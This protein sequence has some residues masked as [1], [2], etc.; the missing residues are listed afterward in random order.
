MASP[1]SSRLDAGPGTRDG[2][3]NNDGHDSSDEYLIPTPSSG[4]SDEEVPLLGNERKGSAS[5]INSSYGITAIGQNP[6]RRPFW[7]KGDLEFDE[8]AIA[9]QES[10]FDE[11]TLAERYRPSPD[12]ENIH[13]FD[14]SA[15]WTW[16]EERAVVRKIDRR[17]MSFACIAFMAL[18]LDRANL[19]QALS[20]NFLDDLGLSTNDFNLGHS[21][22]RLAFLCIE[23]PSQ[24]LSKRIGPDRFLP[25]QMCLWS[26]V[27]ISQFWLQGKKSF[28]VTRALL[29]LFEG[30]F[31]PEIILYL[32]YFYKSQELSIRVAVFY[33]TMSL[34][35][36]FAGFI[37][38][39]LLQMRGFCGLEGWRWLFLIEGVV[40]FVVGMLAA[41]LIPPSITETASWFRG[42]NGWFNKREETIMVNRVLR[43]DPSKGDMHNRQAITWKL[44]R[45][46]LL[47]YDLWPLYILGILWSLPVVPEQQYFT[48]I[49]RDQGFSTS[50]TNLLTIPTMF[51]SMITVTAITH[52]SELYN[53]RS[54]VSIISQLWAL[55]FLVW[56]YA[57]D[58]SEANPWLVW[59]ILTLLIA[60]PSPHAILVSWNSRNSNSVRL[61]TISAAI[62]N[63]CVQTAGMIGSN[64]YRSDDRPQ[65]RRGNQVLIGIACFNITIYLVVKVYYMWRNKF[66]SEKWGTMSEE[67]KRQYLDASQDAGNKRLEFVFAH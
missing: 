15:R 64:I 19:S 27:S 4:S 31:I 65:Y 12:W 50:V 9:T 22:F 35:N 7:N 61:R 28:I 38:V 60:Y 54:L 44:F 33:A 53:E 10:V 23:L 67:E 66:K 30:G 62:Y 43:D 5:T 34:A 58:T 20:D 13:R 46:S 36:I 8:D 39:P 45:Q 42:K 11:P 57:T 17:I 25:I 32:S 6:R 48:L 55:V 29:A 3:D 14:P 18:Q 52:I 51:L 40:T 41:V 2:G 1:S 63:M 47:D 26:I 49:L 56:L 59:L 37:S 21:V 16:R 24:V